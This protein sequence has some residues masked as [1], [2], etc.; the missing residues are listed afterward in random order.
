MTAVV[1]YA[2][3]Q[4]RLVIEDGGE[5]T[6]AGTLNVPGFV[7]GA[8][9][10]V[11]LAFAELYN[12]AT[13]FTLPP[14]R[15]ERPRPAAPRQLPKARHHVGPRSE[16]LNGSVRAYLKEH[17]TATLDDLDT[18]LQPQP[19]GMKSGRQRLNTAIWSLQHQG[20]AERSPDG[21]WRLT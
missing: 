10:D 7:N 12:A 9:V 13:R 17:G 20:K 6:E 14:P 4:L 19:V 15:Q 21:S 2:A 16:S 11:G 3:G 5:R 1:V 8:V 18:A